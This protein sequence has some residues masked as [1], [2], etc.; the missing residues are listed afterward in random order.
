M[1]VI[2]TNPLFLTDKELWTMKAVEMPFVLIQALKIFVLEIFDTV[3]MI[4][5]GVN[6]PLLFDWE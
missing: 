1:I 4:V 2:G 6:V 3:L 5:G